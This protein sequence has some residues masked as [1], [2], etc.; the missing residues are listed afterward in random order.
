[1]TP[2]A[3]PEPTDR[4]ECIEAKKG[5]VAYSWFVFKHGHTGPVTVGWLD[6]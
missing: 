3:I 5:S 2:A 1:M 4:C 6:G